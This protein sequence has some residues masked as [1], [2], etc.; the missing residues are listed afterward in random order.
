MLT[1]TTNAAQAIRD[2]TANAP[3]PESSGIRISAKGPEADSLVLS[4][5]TGPEPADEVV[6]KEGARVY[7]DETAAVALGDKAL[8]AGETA[9]GG[10]S[11][12]VTEQP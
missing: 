8:D 1:L 12:T 6:E 4:L 2:L 10:L 5:A 9:E 3:Q 11:F 7:L